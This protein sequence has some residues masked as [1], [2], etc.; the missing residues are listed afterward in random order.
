MIYQKP[1]S[2]SFV[3]LKRKS[4][5]YLWAGLATKLSLLQGML[6]VCLERGVVEDL[7]FR[8]FLFAALWF[9]SLPCLAHL[10]FRCCSD[11]CHWTQLFQLGEGCRP[12]V[13]PEHVGR[14]VC[15]IKKLHRKAVA[16]SKVVM[17]SLSEKLLDLEMLLTL[18]EERGKEGTGEQ[19]W[20]IE[21]AWPFL[22]SISP[23]E[24]F[25]KRGPYRIG[26]VY[27]KAKYV[28]YTDE[29]FREEK[30]PLE[31]EKHL[32]ILGRNH[33]ATQICFQCQWDWCWYQGYQLAVAVLSFHGAVRGTEEVFHSSYT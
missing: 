33:P 5:L 30:Q 20:F 7:S 13:F 22:F 11:L 18:P 32:G 28:E 24:Q 21:V 16:C 29:S 15:R 14:W 26:G 27:W 9:C 19:D 4:S 17:Q 23:A 6:C 10:V 25:F 3:E 1:N 8:A 12:E 31:E 2:N